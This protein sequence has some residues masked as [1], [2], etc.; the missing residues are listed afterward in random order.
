MA[1]RSVVAPPMGVASPEASMAEAVAWL[2]AAEASSESGTG[3]NRSRCF[4]FLIV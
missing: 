2:A 4:C 3:V 1:V